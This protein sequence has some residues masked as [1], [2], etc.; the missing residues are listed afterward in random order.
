MYH[1]KMQDHKSAVFYVIQFWVG[2]LETGTPIEIF[3]F[4]TLVKL[5]MEFPHE[6][7]TA[8]IHHSCAL[9]LTKYLGVKVILSTVL[10]YFCQF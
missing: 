6:F 5:M 1:F 7:R 3:K 10:K 8:S 9:L 4:H 2:W